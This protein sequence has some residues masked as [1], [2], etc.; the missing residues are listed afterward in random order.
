MSDNTIEPK[1]ESIKNTI[2]PMSISNSITF[3]A[4]DVKNVLIGYQ[5]DCKGSYNV[6]I[7]TSSFCEGDR[8]VVFGTN[9]KVKGNGNVVF[10]DEIEIEGDG[11]TVMG[12][13]PNGPIL[14]Y[15]DLSSIRDRTLY[16]IA[17]LMIELG[18][19]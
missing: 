11:K 8:N 7:G 6:V 1:K 18:R 15:E 4:E 17:H 12:S 5:A 9:C 16:R 2:E 10:G 13:L 14:N 19:M 3:T